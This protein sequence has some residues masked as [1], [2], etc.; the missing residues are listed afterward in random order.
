MSINTLQ[1]AIT[2]RY[3]VPKIDCSHPP[4]EYLAIHGNGRSLRQ[5]SSVTDIWA[6]YGWVAPSKF[7]EPVVPEVLVDSDTTS[8]RGF[9]NSSYTMEASEEQKVNYGSLKLSWKP[10]TWAH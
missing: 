9:S 3:D 10:T 5:F 8:K 6:K 1:E 2:A 7:R 4:K